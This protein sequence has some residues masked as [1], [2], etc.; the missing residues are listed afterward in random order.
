MT[1][2]FSEVGL[3]QTYS[4]EWNWFFPTWARN[5]IF[6]NKFREIAYSIWTGNNKHSSRQFFVVI[7]V[8]FGKSLQPESIAKAFLKAWNC[9]VLSTRKTFRCVKVRFE[10]C[11][12]RISFV[13]AL[14]SFP[15]LQVTVPLFSVFNRTDFTSSTAEVHFNP[16]SLS[17]IFRFQ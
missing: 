16:D 10:H 5:F 14:N 2:F 11:L 9:L 1:T 6:S 17:D 12:S 15:A 3:I 8:G 7:S 4:G 13:Y